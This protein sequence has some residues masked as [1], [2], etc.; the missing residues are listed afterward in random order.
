MTHF[1]VHGLTSAAGQALNGRAGRFPDGQ[2]HG[3][4]ELDPDSDARLPCSLDGVME[5][6]SLRRTNLQLLPPQHTAQ[7]GVGVGRNSLRDTSFNAI[8]ISYLDRSQTTTVVSG[9]CARSVGNL[10]AIKALLRTDP[11]PGRP[12]NIMATDLNVS[13]ALSRAAAGKQVALPP[14]LATLLG[15]V[16]GLIAR[17][18][19]AHP[20]PLVISFD[21]HRTLP[22]HRDGLNTVRG[23]ARVAAVKDGSY[24]IYPCP[25][26]SNLDGLE[27]SY[28]YICIR[29]APFPT[30]CGM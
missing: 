8:T 18:A 27:V 15:D 20:A 19:A 26:E 22:D 4:L 5:N 16:S 29:I 12:L 11:E 14:P 21:P 25:H 10:T 7:Y 23:A 6:K 3:G 28:I 13:I 1:I 24:H 30:G 9:G 2:I 17:R